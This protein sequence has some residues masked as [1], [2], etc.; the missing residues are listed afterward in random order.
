MTGLCTVYTDWAS[1]AK[2][3]PT[4]SPFSH[5]C[6]KAATVN[7]ILCN[8]K[9]RLQEATPAEGTPQ[10]SGRAAFNPKAVVSGSGS[11][12]PATLPLWDCLEGGKMST[13]WAWTKGLKQENRRLPASRKS[14]KIRNHP[15]VFITLFLSHWRSPAIWEVIFPLILILTRLTNDSYAWLVPFFDYQEFQNHCISKLKNIKDLKIQNEW[16][17]L[18]LISIKWVIITI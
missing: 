17:L 10:L 11:R 6:L 9:Q 7:F 3:S 4:K 18:M 1:R 8:K 2:G 5:Q 16:F 15:Q 12:A 13:K 14:S